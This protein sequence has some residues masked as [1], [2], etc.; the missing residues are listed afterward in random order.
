MDVRLRKSIANRI[1]SLSPTEHDEIYKI[2]TN[3]G[4]AVTHNKNGA[5]VNL[6]VVPDNVMSEISDFVEFC[7]ANKES[8]DAYDKRMSECKIHNDFSSLVRE[9]TA[10]QSG[11]L[12]DN[13]DAEDAEEAEDADASHPTQGWNGV[14]KGD[15]AAA[16]VTS[17]SDDVKRLVDIAT[18]LQHLDLKTIRKAAT[19]N[20][21]A[22]AKK[23]YMTRKAR[24]DGDHLPDL[25]E[26]E[27]VCFAC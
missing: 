3:H 8:L 2:I 10:G 21:F 27:G 13:G 16:D 12:D 25:L 19:K 24:S 14:L 26:E 7:L 11:D 18:R 23:R 9:G 15:H 6:A 17:Q 4:V 20:K 5:F 22:T 1:G